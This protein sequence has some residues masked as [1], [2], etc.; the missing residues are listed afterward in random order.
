[1]RDLRARWRRRQR[2]EGSPSVVRSLQRGFTLIE[3]ILGIFIGLMILT[4]M[5]RQH[6]Q[7][8]DDNRAK[9]TA[10]SMQA[11]SQM[12]AQYLVSNRAAIAAAAEDG[13]D[14]DNL[15]AINVDPVTGVGTTAVN[16]FKKTCAIDVS[17]LKHKR[18]LPK[19]YPETN[20]YNQKWVAI[21]RVVYDDYDNDPGTAPTSNGDM[22]IL[23]VGAANNGNERPGSHSAITLAAD[24]M[25]GNGG[26]IPDGK[27]GACEFD[28]GSTD[29]NAKRACGVGGAWNVDVT[30]FID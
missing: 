24:L 8:V 11:F 27:L 21:Y 25:G 12:A 26:V 29:P 14:A 20:A 18:L 5:A 2:A 7:A 30:E 16:T 13:T 3:A 1:M 17:Y 22:E 6:A 28:P 10:E 9:N 23:V 15:C 4:F 19:M